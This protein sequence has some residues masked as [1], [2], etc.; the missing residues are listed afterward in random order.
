MSQ[1]KKVWII[2]EAGVNHNGSLSN[3]K[4]LIDAAKAAGADAVKFQTFVPELVISKHA[5][6]AN[7]QEKNTG[8]S[9]SQLDMVRKLRLNLDEHRELIA[10]CILSGIEFLSTPF[11]LESIDTLHGLGL[12][13]VKIPSGE[14]TNAPYLKKLGRLNKQIIL[15]TGM[16]YLGEI[17]TA[18]NVL[19][20]AGTDRE[21]ISL[22]HCNT[23]YPTPMQDVNLR[24][25]TTMRQAFGLE[26]GYSDHT[27]GIEV[28][29]A[30]VAMGATIIEK[31][32]TLDKTMEGP[33]HKASLEPQELA[34][35]VMAIRNIEKALGDGIKRPSA[36]ETK[37]IAV[38]RKSIH[39]A[40]N[41][42]KGHVIT[43]SDLLMKRPGNGITPF[44]LENIVGR[45]FNREVFE[46]DM[47]QWSF[48]D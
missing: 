28:S 24:A 23:E 8:N 9:E 43:D 4:K 21:R 6:K 31:H 36:S 46:D 7:Y 2:A 18:V 41:F 15:S 37:N 26:T 45:T 19:V 34:A 29:T 13:T 39:I 16:C 27:L 17:E 42:P 32:F 40:A 11:D 30:A 10:H 38:A 1:R 35:M 48:L 12:N 25:M 47:L 22:L 33:D 44:E 5:A 14:V 20:A 3:A